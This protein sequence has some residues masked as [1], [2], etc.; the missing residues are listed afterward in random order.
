MAKFEWVKVEHR[1]AY[2]NPTIPKELIAST[3]PRSYDEMP[4]G[5]EIKV[6]VLASYEPK[7]MTILQFHR[8]KICL[9]QCSDDQNQQ[10]MGFLMSFPK[11]F[12]S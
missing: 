12:V 3:F 6:L 7:L 5:T 4:A 1:D 8:M 2:G 9:I 10:K 11:I